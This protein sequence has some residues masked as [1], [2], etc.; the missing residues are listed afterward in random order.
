MALER[1]DWAR[2]GTARGIVVFESSPSGGRRRETGKLLVVKQ[3]QRSVTRSVLSY[4][5]T[6]SIAAD[7]Q[8]SRSNDTDQ[9]T[10]RL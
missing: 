5:R 3:A 8:R 2:E 9:K 10:R 4:V 7:I 6:S 1:N